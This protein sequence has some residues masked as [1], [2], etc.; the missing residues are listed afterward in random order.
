MARTVLMLAALVA[1]T[2]PFCAALSPSP[3]CPCAKQPAEVTSRPYEEKE[4][5]SARHHELLCCPEALLGSL[6][7]G[8]K[9][10]WAFKGKELHLNESRDYCTFKKH[11]ICGSETLQTD[12]ALPTDEGNYTCT[13]TTSDGAVATRT[14]S[15]CVAVSETRREAPVESYVSPPQLALPKQEARF[16]CQALVGLGGCGRFLE[17]NI[18]WYK[19]G[20]DGSK[21]P[22]DLL[23]STE[24]AK[25][26]QKRGIVKHELNIS[27]VES[28]HYGS[29][30]CIVT[31]QYGTLVLNSTLSNGVP[32]VM[33]LAGQYRA[34]L[35]VM[36]MTGI[37]LVVILLFWFRCRMMV[38]LYYREKTF[39]PDPED[40]HKYDLFVIN[41]DSASKW[42]WR[43]FVPSLETTLGY[44]CFLP[45]RN[46]AGG[47]LLIDA[48]TEAVSRCRCVVV[49]V[50]PC[51]LENPWLLWALH[52]GVDAA[53]TSNTRLFGVVLQDIRQVP[54]QPENNKARSILK[55]LRKIDVPL[56]LRLLE[57][58][59]PADEPITEEP[60][61]CIE[62]RNL[63]LPDRTHPALR[64][65]S[66]SPKNRRLANMIL[67]SNNTSRE[68]RERKSDRQ[69]K[70]MEN[71]EAG[72]KK[73]L[74]KGKDRRNPKKEG[75]VV[76]TENEDDLQDLGSPCSVTP[77]LF[78]N[79]ARPRRRM[80][81]M[82]GA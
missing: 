37:M 42:V 48:I 7:D 78:P 13:I 66:K 71:A 55:T 12:S 44:S 46:M 67:G 54:K 36:T 30:I 27:R 23:P 39:V 3:H 76:F 69:K 4:I 32:S 82:V 68:K 73:E 41:G 15:L 20:E 60:P 28:V 75:P 19:V 10:T 5:L 40:K 33:M 25:V 35:V 24:T 56:C 59:A 52:R 21:T 22:A 62:N 14:I 26:M 61:R 49:V 74:G 2:E 29:Y 65:R 6:R 38:A 53:L 63:S 51:V 80:N 11:P 77:F 17:H 81:R 18:S 31:N 58:A 16:S 8:Y 1:V 57:D 50:T 64:S 34:A 72:L 47:E 79:R 43:V 70:G 45:D 9:I